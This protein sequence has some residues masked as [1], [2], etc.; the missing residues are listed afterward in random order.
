MPNQVNIAKA[1]LDGMLLAAF[2]INIFRYN[3]F[4]WQIDEV[5]LCALNLKKA[6]IDHSQLSAKEK[7]NMKRQW[8]T[9]VETVSRGYK[10]TLRLAG[11]L[12]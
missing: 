11:R 10:D 5:K 6:G 12:Q 2:G 3:A 9:W 7:E 4:E 8:E 1:Y